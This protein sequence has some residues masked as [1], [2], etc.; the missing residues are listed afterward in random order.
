MNTKDRIMD[1][2]LHMFS[3][4]GYE[5]VSVRDICG[6]VGIKESTLYYHFKNKK[7]ILDSLVLRFKTHIADL[8]GHIDDIG[9]GPDEK[10]REISENSLLDSYMM[11]RYLFDPFCNL[12][13]RFMMMEQFH[14]EEMR[15]LYEK[16]I[17]SDPYDIQMKI[18]KMLAPKEAVSEEEIEWIVRETNAYM[19]MLT[20][21]YLLNGELNEERKEAYYRDVHDYMSRK[22][23]GGPEK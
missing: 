3:A 14:N 1:V 6:E 11:D 7:D 12:M 17:F 4:R 13:L 10:Q 16:T 22:L 8:L 5:A 23:C 18:F 15:L 2:A 9:A 19:T 20:F 21:K